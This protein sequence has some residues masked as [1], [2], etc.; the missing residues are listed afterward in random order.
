MSNLGNQNQLSQG[1]NGVRR[2]KGNGSHLD[3][4]PGTRRGPSGDHL[5]QGRSGGVTKSK[6]N[7]SHLSP[8]PA[9]RM[10]DRTSDQQG[11]TRFGHDRTNPT[12][13]A[14]KSGDHLA[15]QNGL[16]PSAQKSRR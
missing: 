16:K 14:G 1:T 8:I 12:L 4:R 7:G 13:G 2:S 3:Q 10:V 6:A 9:A 11:G 15:P 5:A